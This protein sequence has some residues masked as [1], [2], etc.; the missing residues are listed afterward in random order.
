MKVINYM[1]NRFS[2]QPFTRRFLLFA[3]IL[4]GFRPKAVAY[5]SLATLF[6]TQKQTNYL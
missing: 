1:P 6:L 5:G 4:Q 3:V 2:K